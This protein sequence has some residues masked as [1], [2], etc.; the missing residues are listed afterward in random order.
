M[1]STFFAVATTTARYTIQNM[2]LAL[3]RQIGKLASGACNLIR[4]KTKLYFF[5]AKFSNKTVNTH[6][7]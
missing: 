3:K 1:F 6:R 2:H 5:L 4:I 7:I